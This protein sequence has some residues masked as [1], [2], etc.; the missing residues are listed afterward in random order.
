MNPLPRLR[1][2]KRDPHLLAADSEDPFFFLGDAAWELFHRLSPAESEFY[3]RTRAV[4]GFNLVCAVARA[5]W[6]GLQWDGL[7]TPNASGY[8]PLHG[9]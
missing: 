6:D 5:E 2:S 8:L 7:H 3:F 1:V 4:Q 9:D